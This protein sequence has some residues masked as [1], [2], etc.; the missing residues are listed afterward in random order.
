MYI[1]MGVGII[2]WTKLYKTIYDN[3]DI[4]SINLFLVGSIY[5]LLA[6]FF[7]G[8]D[9]SLCNNLYISTHF[10]WHI[11]SALALHYYIMY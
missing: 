8:I 3:K 5:N 7:W 2:R 11:F 6:L 9:I 10:L 1:L 4:E